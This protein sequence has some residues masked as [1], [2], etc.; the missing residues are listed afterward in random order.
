MFESE[1]V[2][3]LATKTWR[4]RLVLLAA[5]AVMR[6]NNNHGLKE[7]GEHE[8][9][10]LEKKCDI[11]QGR[12]EIDK[13][14]LLPK[15]GEP[16]ILE[17]CLDWLYRLRMSLSIHGF[18]PETDCIALARVYGARCPGRPRNNLY[19][20]YLFY[21]KAWDSSAEVR[22]QIGC[23]SKE[24]C[25][26]KYTQQLDKE[27]QRLESLPKK[28]KPP[29]M[30]LLACKLPDGPE[31]DSLLRCQASLERSI[32]RTLSQLERLQRM[33]LGQPVLPKLEVR[34][35]MS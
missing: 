18:M 5:S 24:D 35:S 27:I 1:L 13:V 10:T 17:D 6:K 19:D 8:E 9:M 14:G 11:E 23:S 28:P 16:G 4:Q 12:A 31:L 30:G 20:V 33:R 15:I 34:H 3:F 29:E 32:D 2:D 22:L 21:K 25:A 7:R 26:N